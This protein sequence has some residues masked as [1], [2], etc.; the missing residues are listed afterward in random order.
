MNN[1]ANTDPLSTVTKAQELFKTT[2]LPLLLTLAGPDS[3]AYT[4]EADSLE[5][6][7]KSTFYG[8]TWSRLSSI[9]QKYDPNDL[10]IVKGGVGSERWDDAGMCRV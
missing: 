3:G 7:F 8:T 9:K 6:D 1:W 10:F 2:Q 5:A 4:N